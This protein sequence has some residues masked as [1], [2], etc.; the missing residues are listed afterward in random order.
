VQ[1]PLERV[2]NHREAYVAAALTMIRAYIAAGAPSVCEPFG[3]YAGWSAMV[4]SPLIWLD[5][6][7]P[8]ESTDSARNE[9]PELAS[10]REL[11]SLWSDYFDLDRPYATSRI[12]EV[13]C[14]APAPNDFNRQP[15]KALLLQVAGDRGDRVSTTRLGWWLRRISGRVVE[16]HRLTLSHPNK[17]H[18][19]FSLLRVR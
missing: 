5:E 13:A 17:A 3:S 10:I 14:E 16:G 8:V 11:F 6:P 12:V 1:S 15:L 7:D 4:R 9:D 18:A 19:A 2:L